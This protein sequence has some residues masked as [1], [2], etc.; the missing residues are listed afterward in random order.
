M[1]YLPSFSY[2]PCVPLFFYQP[3]IFTCLTCFPF[4][5]C[6]MCLHFC[7]GLT[8][9]IFLWV[10]LHFLCAY[11]LFTC[12]RFPYMPSPFYLP[13]IFW[14]D[15]RLKVPNMLWFLTVFIFFFTCLHFLH[16]VTFYSQAFA[17]LTCFHTLLRLL[18]L[19]KRYKLFM[20]R[21]CLSNAKGGYWLIFFI[22]AEPDGGH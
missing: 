3:S 13:G 11:I 6:L 9:L 8:C 21:T 10:L 19:V 14:R 17:F 1:T 22:F 12:I 18:I 20:Y 16:E 5:A 7:T 4:F 2:A 15:L